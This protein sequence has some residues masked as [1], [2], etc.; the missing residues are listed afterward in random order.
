MNDLEKARFSNIFR[1]LVDETM[2]S[3]GD[4]DGLLILK[5]NP[6]DNKISEV[7][8]YFEEWQNK[9]PHLS[10]FPWFRT[11]SDGFITFHRSQERIFI[12]NKS[13]FWT[14]SWGPDVKIEV[15]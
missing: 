15:W 13:D 4:G 2:A 14:P 1:V 12:T 6:P 3:S 10:K 7:A 11:N 8:D 9:D 5:N